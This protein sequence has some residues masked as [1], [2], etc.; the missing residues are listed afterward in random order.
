MYRYTWFDKSDFIM[1]IVPKG[2]KPESWV[3]LK[4]IE[5]I[6]PSAW[7]EHCLECSEPEC[8][9]H[10]PYWLERFDKKCKKTGYGFKRRNDLIKYYPLAVQFKFRPW[11]KI[12][13]AVYKGNISP[14][15]FRSMD[16]A[17]Y[18]MDRGA[19]IVSHLMSPFV[20]NYKI[21]RA[22][23]YL[24]NKRVEK[25]KGKKL[26]GKFLFQCYS[27][28]SEPYHMIFEF[29]RD[30]AVIFRQSS[31]IRVGYNQEVLELTDKI[32]DCMLGSEKLQMRYYPEN[33]REAEVLVFFSDF[34][35]LKEDSGLVTVSE[36]R[37]GLTPAKKVKCVAWDL[38][39][40]I[41][42]GVLIESNIEDLSLRSGIEDMIKSLDQRG[43]I[44]IVVSKNDESDVLPV[45]KRLGI[46]D[47]FVYIFANWQ[48]KSVNL[49]IAAEVLNIN[50]DTFALI[51]DSEFERGEVK[52]ALP[53]VRVYMETEIEGILDTG[54]FNVSVTGDSK[55]R[56]RMYQ[57]EAKRK[58]VKTGFVGNDVEFIKS[59]EMEL[60]IE[61]INEGSEK[62]SLE[63][64]Q[65]TNQLNL[66][67]RKYKV[68]DFHRLIES[69]E[70]NAFAVFCKDKYGDYG[71][72]GFIIAAMAEG[73]NLVIS[74][75]AVSCRVAE[76]WV[77]PT[78][79]MWMRDRWCA[80]RITF[81]G[82]YN[83]K[84]DR[85][86]GTLKKYGM[87]EELNGEWHREQPNEMN[88]YIDF[89]DVDYPQVIKIIDNTV[90]T[91]WC[92]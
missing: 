31:E 41:W 88:L 9:G 87:K 54:P 26:P 10:C 78:L 33:D 1:D 21:G 89:S 92:Y 20:H 32:I 14:A 83:R 50:I 68:E 74:E 4:D 45:L 80:E 76:K 64:V 84:N 61:Y 22:E 72:V 6:I 56:R 90:E 34:V 82:V 23:E 25:I 36:N 17:G 18:M 44:Q 49:K 63:L 57:E 47:Y 5:I 38:D 85:L 8:Y 2:R 40:T 3:R 28:E 66:S 37:V 51:D 81:R 67:G 62:R 55:N 24:K 19:F 79:L 77:E 60:R 59:C 27:D 46:I 91:G 15:K 58:K 75:Y 16:K 73:Q 65:R 52:E 30:E 42:D 29:L 53:Q 43:I 71:Q 70:K 48:R 12:Q 69:H 13:T 7:E 35:C 39:H 11:A 86:V